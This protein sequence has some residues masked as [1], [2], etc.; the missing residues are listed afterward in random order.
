MQ[1]CGLRHVGRGYL[2]CTRG[3]EV[4]PPQRPHGEMDVAMLRAEFKRTPKRK[5]PATTN[6]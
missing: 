2:T 3:A 5:D 4:L 1:V 6:A